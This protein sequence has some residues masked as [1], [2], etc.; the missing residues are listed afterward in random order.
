MIS[1]ATSAR[2]YRNRDIAD[3]N[4]AMCTM[5]VRKLMGGMCGKPWAKSGLK[6]KD[7]RSVFVFS[8]DLARACASSNC[9]TCF[10]DH[11]NVRN[12]DWDER[13]NLVLP[14]LAGSVLSRGYPDLLF[15]YTPSLF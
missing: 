13:V 8:F 10:R 12:R 2:T 6:D 4:C 11:A 1:G 9:C 7:V 14:N 15:L 5:I 3:R